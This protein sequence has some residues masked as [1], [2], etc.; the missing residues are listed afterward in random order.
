MIAS[1]ALLTLGVSAALLLATGYTGYQWGRSSVQ[2]KWDAQEQALTKAR[3]DLL[4]LGIRDSHQL[5]LAHLEEERHVRTYTESLIA[6]VPVYIEEELTCPELSS[7]WSR[8]H[9]AAA[10]GAAGRGSATADAAATG[11]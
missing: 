10:R 6:Q 3:G 1:Q 9:D 5:G 4:L 2:D 8:L 11:P 7:D